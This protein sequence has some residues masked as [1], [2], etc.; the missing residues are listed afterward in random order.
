VFEQYM[1]RLVESGGPEPADYEEL[2]GWYNRIGEAV[3]GLQI[4]KED[5]RALFATLGESVTSTKTMQGLVWV[6]PHGYAGDFEIIDRLYQQWVAPEPHL[7]RWD[8]YFHAQAAPRAVRN[9]KDYFHRWLRQWESQPDENELR[10]LNIASG[11]GRDMRDYFEQHPH[12]RVRFECV[13]YDREAI[14]YAGKLC[15]SFAERILFRHGNALRFRPTAPA[16]LVWSAGLFDYLDDRQFVFLLRHLLR[17]V[18]PGGEVVVGNF[19]PNNPTRIYMEVFGDWVLQHREADHLLAL[20]CE[21]GAPDSAIRI[22]QE[23]EGVNLF[24]HIQTDSV[25]ARLLKG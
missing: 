11:P 14:E 25:A 6:K 4:R 12:S 9:R 5:V 24:L 8:E 23:P 21:A 19:S 10:V 13:D 18:V 15:S 16:R 3:A 1:R 17:F 7:R 20:A 22:G 2:T